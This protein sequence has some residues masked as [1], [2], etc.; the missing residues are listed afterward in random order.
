MRVMEIIPDSS[1]FLGG[2]KELRMGENQWLQTEI[3]PTPNIFYGAIS[4]KF[5]SENLGLL[6]KSLPLNTRVIE[7]GRIFLKVNNKHYVQLPRDCLMKE[8][9]IK[10]LKC[11][12]D[13]HNYS[14]YTYNNNVMVSYEDIN[15]NY[16]FNNDKLDYILLD[17]KVKT[18]YKVGIAL[19]NKKTKD[20]YLYRLDMLEFGKNVSYVV[21]Y[22]IHEQKDNKYIDIPE[23]GFLKFGGEGR[24]C[25]Y[26]IIENSRIATEV[27][28]IKIK[29]KEFSIK[30]T[31]ISP[32]ILK[33]NVKE[34]IYGK[35]EIEWKI[36]TLITDKPDILSTYSNND[37]IRI[38]KSGSVIILDLLDK[39]KNINTMKE[40]R[41]FLNKNF[42]KFKYN[43]LEGN[44]IRDGFS[45][46]EIKILEETK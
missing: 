29:N 27:D 31:A 7:I 34:K 20:G 21:E 41:E 32:I 25:K 11:K 12:E 38:L 39:N 15:K 33:H 23:K 1:I 30:I 13:F 35:L 45:E 19:K 43:D 6:K 28:D 17:G 18:S 16:F 3:F 4:S 44:T 14:D 8:G 37:K 46:V 22:D 5:L 42:F 40:L 24:V 10:I 26:K 9:K 2:L 36:K